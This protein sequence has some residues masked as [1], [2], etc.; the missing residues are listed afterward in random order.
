MSAR[1]RTLLERAARYVARALVA[2]VVAAAARCSSALAVAGYRLRFAGNRRA[3]VEYRNGAASLRGRYEKMARLIPPGSRIVELGVGGSRL[4][5]LLDPGVACAT[6]DPTA[7]GAARLD[8]RMDSAPLSSAG[9]HAEMAAVGGLLE[10]LHD[11]EPAVVW[12]GRHFSL[13]VVSYPSTTSGRAPGF[14]RR[15]FE[16][17]GNAHAEAEV[18]ALFAA[19]GLRCVARDPRP[20]ERVFLFASERPAAGVG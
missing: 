7:P 11:I 18:V 20:A 9:G 2:G 15:L 13:C 16:R 6:A 3:W 12:L 4:G 19:S 17:Y 1:R 5:P 14:A 10:H 8:W